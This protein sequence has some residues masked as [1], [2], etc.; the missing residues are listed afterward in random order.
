MFCFIYSQQCIKI[1]SSHK[2]CG[3]VSSVFK[4]IIPYNTSPTFKEVGGVTQPRTFCRDITLTITKLIDFYSQGIFTFLF[5]TVFNWNELERH[6]IAKLILPM[7]SFKELSSLCSGLQ[8]YFWFQYKEHKV[9]LTKIPTN[10]IFILLS[11]IFF[12]KYVICD[13]GFLDVKLGILLCFLN[14]FGIAV[15]VFIY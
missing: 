2:M 9:C 12:P 7:G 13:M 4:N 10:D 15:P 14:G 6:L 5:V 11:F 3:F 1:I 8:N